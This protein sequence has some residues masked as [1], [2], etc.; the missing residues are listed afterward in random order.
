[1]SAAARP[2]FTPHFARPDDAVDVRLRT[3][4]STRSRKLS[5]RWPYELGVDGEHADGRSRAMYC[6]RCAADGRDWP[7]VSRDRRIRGLRRPVPL[8]A[9]TRRAAASGRSAFDSII[10]RTTWCHKFLI[11]QS[12]PA[13]FG[14]SA[15]EPRQTR[16]NPE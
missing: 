3:P 10:G 5:R 11:F 13:R 1:V 14:N 7:R 12:L 16:M 15:R 2:L 9:L 6:G 8:A 4:F